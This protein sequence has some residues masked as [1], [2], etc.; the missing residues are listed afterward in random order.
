MKSNVNN[1]HWNIFDSKNIWITK[2]VK[3]ELFLQ[4]LSIIALTRKLFFQH[5]YLDVSSVKLKLQGKVLLIF[6]LEWTR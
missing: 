3:P 5:Q 2:V 4:N 6:D 1:Y